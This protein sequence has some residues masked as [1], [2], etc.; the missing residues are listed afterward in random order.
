MLDRQLR[1]GRDLDLG[2]VAERALRERR[3]PA[4]R[5]DLDI[6]HVHPHRP[7]L[8]GSEH[9]H[10]SSSQRELP[11]LGHL[12]Y[13]LIPGCDQF[14][15]ALLEVQQLADAQRERVRAQ[16]RI[17]DLLRQRHRA[18]DDHR[19]LILLCLVRGQQRVQRRHAQAH[20]MG[21]RREV[22]LVGDAPRWVVAH[23][24]GRQPCAQVC[25]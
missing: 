15:G 14:G 13:T 9:V 23:P 5:F 4:Q 11:A 10:E 20:E 8:G 7:I 16:R 19:W 3:E 18:D 1:R 12:I 25:G 17:G 2:H 21:R 6:E 22:R 24:A